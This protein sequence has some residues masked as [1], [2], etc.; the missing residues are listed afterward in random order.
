MRLLCTG[1]SGNETT[2]YGGSGNETTIQLN[3]YQLL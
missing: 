3:E 1:G 2:L